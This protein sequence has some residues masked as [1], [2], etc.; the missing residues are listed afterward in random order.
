VLD[1]AGFAW[2]VNASYHVVFCQT[3]MRE[4][5]RTLNELLEVERELCDRLD[6]QISDISELHHNEMINIKQVPVIV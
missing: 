4:D 5:Y 6:E 2:L 1:W 3:K